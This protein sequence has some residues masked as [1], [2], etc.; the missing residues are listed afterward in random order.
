[1]NALYKI[2]R[3]HQQQRQQQRHTEQ[4]LQTL[5]GLTQ[6]ILQAW[7]SN[8]TPFHASIAIHTGIEL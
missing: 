2:L 6:N 5:N 1:M 8:A 3:G 7:F 4:M